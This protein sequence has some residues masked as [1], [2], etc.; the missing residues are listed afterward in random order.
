MVQLPGSGK[1]PPPTEMN[2]AYTQ[3][4]EVADSIGPLL[5]SANGSSWYWDP[6]NEVDKAIVAL[7]KLRRAGAGAGG[8]AESGDAAVRDQLAVTSFEAV[9]WLASRAVSYMDEHEF[10]EV[11]ARERGGR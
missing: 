1:N 9:V 2:P 6:D 7:C 10:P 11:V 8:I 4:G 5:E 3:L